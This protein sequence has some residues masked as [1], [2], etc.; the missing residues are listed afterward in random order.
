MHVDLMQI[1]TEWLLLL[2]SAS[3]PLVFHH[4]FCVAIEK[5]KLFYKKRNLGKCIAFR[6]KW[7]GCFH[8]RD[9]FKASSFCK[10]TL[11][12]YISS[13]NWNPGKSYLLC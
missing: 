1:T 4:S 12:P 6:R 10:C 11:R 8:R 7:M 9:L 2:F 3:L 13:L 5:G